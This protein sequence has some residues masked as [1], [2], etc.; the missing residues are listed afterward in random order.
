MRLSVDSKIHTAIGEL[1]RSKRSHRI[2]IVYSK[3]NN[4]AK[5]GGEQ[6]PIKGSNGVENKQETIIGRD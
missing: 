3:L 1:D 4:L 5:K 2:C 6:D